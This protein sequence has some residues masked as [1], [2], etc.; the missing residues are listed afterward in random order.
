MSAEVTPI[1]ASEILERLERIESAAARPA[2]KQV[3]TTGEAAEFLGVH[4][5]TFRRWAARWRVLPCGH[6]RWPLHRLNAGLQREARQGERKPRKAT[7][8]A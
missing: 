5:I 8:T 7:V 3:M 1:W 4:P 6:G 2:P